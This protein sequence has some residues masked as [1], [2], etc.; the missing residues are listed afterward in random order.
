[1]PQ[2][3]YTI[4]KL[5]GLTIKAKNPT[6]YY[7]L[8]TYYNTAKKLGTVKSGDLV[9]VLYSWVGGTADRPLHLQFRRG[10][11]TFYYVPMLPGQIDNDFNRAQGLTTTQ[12][13]K[14]KD[15]DKN[16]SFTDKLLDYFR[17]S[18]KIVLYGG[19]ALVAL[20]VI[21]KNRKK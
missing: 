3:S 10:D 5:I 6:A 13:D 8:P 17:K 12:E 16:K 11:G 7:D 21:L 9:G 14:E 1:M 15:E 4:D 20:N 19:L 18:G 2:Q